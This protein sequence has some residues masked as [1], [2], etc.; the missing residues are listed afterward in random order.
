MTDGINQ[1]RLSA[2]GQ[3]GFESSEM[4]SSKST[5]LVFFLALLSTQVAI[6]QPRARD[7]AF[8]QAAAQE[9]DR[10]AREDGFSGTIILARDGVPI[11]TVA[12]GL[13]DRQ[14]QLPNR[15][16]TK[17][18]VESVTKQFTATAILLLKEQG[19][20]KLSDPISQYYP[21]MPVSLPPIT[22]AQLLTHSSGIVDCKPCFDANSRD[23]KG[24]VARSLQS[25]LAFQPGAGMLYSNAGYGL[26][27]ITI[28]K[29]SGVSYAQF[30]QQNV[31]SSLRM[32]NSGAGREPEMIAK[33]YICPHGQDSCRDGIGPHFE[34]VAGFSGVYSTVDDM[35][36]WTFSLS[37]KAPL[38]DRSRQEMFQDYGHGYGFGWY[39]SEKMGRRLIWHTGSDGPAG[40]AS[41]VEMFPGDH[42]TVIALTNN[43]GLNHGTAVLRINGKD[44]TI[45]ASPVR[46]VV[47]N[48]ERLYFDAFPQ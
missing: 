34:D 31:F 41:I 9:I 4:K 6:G 33:G 37:E 35:L 12:E 15:V 5:L 32:T 19:R 42:V 7:A 26:L 47:D 10:I 43:T 23:Y 2:K 21:D 46:E 38:S 39:L 11:L 22:I 16:E 30:L 45:P 3:P 18:P 17:F 40:Y 1:D 48:I 27:A 8:K 36:R 20:L 28:E 29:V 14:Q 13:Q 44:V 24:Y 25:N